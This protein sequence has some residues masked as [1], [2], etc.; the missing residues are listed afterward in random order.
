MNSVNS[1]VNSVNVTAV[2]TIPTSIRIGGIVFVILAAFG[3]LYI[4][5]TWAKSPWYADRA[6]AAQSAWNWVTS[7]FT[8]PSLV[9][10][11]GTPYT[12]L[13][14]PTEIAPAP[15]SAAAIAAAENQPAILSESWCFV[16]EDTT[17]RWC[18]RVPSSHACDP[19][20]SF[21]SRSDCELVTASSLPL[22]VV[23]QGGATMKPLGP[24]PSMSAM[25]VL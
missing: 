9:N 6:V 1:V 24:M 3:T 16:G 18:V 4:W 21:A 20:R 23:Q 17:G 22:G 8:Q 25:E 5:Y 14:A 13:T 19:D 11:A 15:L 12:P 2:S 7:L 10:A